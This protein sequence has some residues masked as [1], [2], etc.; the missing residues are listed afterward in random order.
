[1]GYHIRIYCY[2]KRGDLVAQLFVRDTTAFV[3]NSNMDLETI[4]EANEFKLKYRKKTLSVPDPLG[5]ITAKRL[6]ITFLTGDLQFKGVSGVEF[7]K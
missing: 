1:M 7:V 4:K 5:Y 3:W 6:R 2:R